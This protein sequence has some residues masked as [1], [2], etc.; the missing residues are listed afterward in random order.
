MKPA[1]ALLPLFAIA[2]SGQTRPN[3]EQL[4]PNAGSCLLLIFVAGMPSCAA[5]DPSIYL[6]TSTSPPTLRPKYL[7]VRV[8]DQIPARQTDGTYLVPAG[9][10][11]LTVWRNGLLQT[12]ATAAA[13]TG[14]LA[15]Y[16]MDANRIV[17]TSPWPAT[18]KVRVAYEVPKH[19]D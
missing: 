16:A 18:D 6:D 17:P 3:G 9:V 13:E 10:A 2:L 7:T 15:D 11:A 5:I 4:T 12:A 19:V 14:P 1:A 8:V